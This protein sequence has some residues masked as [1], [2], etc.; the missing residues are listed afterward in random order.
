MSLP[1]YW[2]AIWFDIKWCIKL[3]SN[4]TIFPSIAHV[5]F[6]HIITGLFMKFLTLLKIIHPIMYLR[7]SWI[8]SMQT[9]TWVFQLN[10]LWSIIIHSFLVTFSW[11]QVL[12]IP[13]FDYCQNKSK[14][15]IK[16]S[17]LFIKRLKTSQNS[18]ETICTTNVALKQKFF[19]TSASSWIIFMSFES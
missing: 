19:L 7:Q 11:F 6:L 15:L 16:L 17:N 9:I 10:A 8:L 1:L 14:N 2:Y 3:N 4:Q 13:L 12:W 18:H 5:L